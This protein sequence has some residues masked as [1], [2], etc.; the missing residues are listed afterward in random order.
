[1]LTGLVLYFFSKRRA[2]KRLGAGAMIL[3]TSLFLLVSVL[4]LWPRQK[5]K[6]NLHW[7]LKIEHTLD[8]LGSPHCAE[9]KGDDHIWQNCVWEGE[10]EIQM[11]F[12]EER[13]FSE[14]A[15]IVW[16]KAEDRKVETI[17]VTS[18]AYSTEKAFER[19]RELSSL[20]GLEDTKLKGWFESVKKGSSED[21]I[22]YFYDFKTQPRIPQ[23]TLLIK[24]IQNEDYRE[25]PWFLSIEF[26]W[27]D[28]N[29]MDAA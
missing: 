18:Q 4:V 3:S 17:A 7:D 9:W 24:R 11:S 20:W 26:R 14:K 22:Q 5:S 16:V 15:K 2:L 23:L 8:Q 19:A 12:P 28:M 21:Y 13:S 1:M 27:Y 25:T 10:G 6:F 29:S